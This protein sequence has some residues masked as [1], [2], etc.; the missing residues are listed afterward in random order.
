MTGGEGEKEGEDGDDD[1]VV[2]VAMVE[3]ETSK[4]PKK[5]LVGGARWSVRS[6]SVR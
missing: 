6:M 5:R 3:R 4:K 1:G 2:V